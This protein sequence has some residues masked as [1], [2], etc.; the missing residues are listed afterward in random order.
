MTLDQRDGPA[1]LR[2]LRGAVGASVLFSALSLVGLGIGW[3]WLFHRPSQNSALEDAGRYGALAGRAALAPFITDDLLTGDKAAIDN[4]AK[5]GHALIKEGK[6][7][8]VKVWSVQ[9]RVLWSDEPKLIGKTFEFDDEERKLLHGEGTL[10]SV[11]NLDDDENQFEI[12]AGETSLLQ[13]YFGSKTPTGTPMVVETYY[14]TSL[15]DSRAA[16]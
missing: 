8:H 7:A 12:Q 2:N 14:P 1:G 10:A 4:I 16:D 5:A 6:A 11:S 13:V 9:G 3:A 15:V